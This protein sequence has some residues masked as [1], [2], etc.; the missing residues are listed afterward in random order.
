M[1]R[2]VIQEKTVT[3]REIE[4]VAKDAG[5]ARFLHRRGTCTVKD[6]RELTYVNVDEKR[7]DEANA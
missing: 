1:P 4:V 7:E 6:V 5:E 3:T 2:Y